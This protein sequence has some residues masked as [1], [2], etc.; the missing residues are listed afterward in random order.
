[1]FQDVLNVWGRMEL[2]RAP[3]EEFLSARMAIEGRAG[4]VSGRSRAATTAQLLGCWFLR[5]HPPSGSTSATVAGTTSTS[6]AGAT[7]T[8]SAGAVSA[9]STGAISATSAGAISATSA[10][11]TAA[12]QFTFSP[13]FNLRLTQQFLALPGDAGTCSAGFLGPD[14]PRPERQ[15]RGDSPWQL[16]IPAPSEGCIGGLWDDLVTLLHDVQKSQPGRTSVHVGGYF[17]RGRA[18]LEEI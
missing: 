1:M 6:S 12:A 14:S 2:P 17:P 15:P 16:T 4:G 11:T 5:R 3:L 13:A 9:T 18:Q 10:G 7:S 8:S